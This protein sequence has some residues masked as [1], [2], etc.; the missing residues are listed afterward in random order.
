MIEIVSVSK[1][2]YTANAAARKIRRVTDAI[3]QLELERSSCEPMAH[4]A[5]MAAE[6]GC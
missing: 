3:C 4:L 2:Q 6:G 5:G 1:G